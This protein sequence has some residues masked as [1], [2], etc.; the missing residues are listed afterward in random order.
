MLK[1][2]GFIYDDI[3]LKH[4]MPHGHPESPQRLIRILDALKNSDIW[5]NLIHIKPMRATEEDIL[6]VYCPTISCTL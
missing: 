4:E 6:L 3:F 2:V 1:K 5:N